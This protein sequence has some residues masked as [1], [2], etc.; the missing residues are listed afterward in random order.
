MESLVS[1][2]GSLSLQPNPRARYATA[3]EKAVF[4]DTLTA[5]IIGPYSVTTKATLTNG[6]CL[7]S[8]VYRAAEAQGFPC[9]IASVLGGYTGPMPGNIRTKEME[10][11]QKARFL[12]S[13]EIT[14]EVNELY[15]AMVDNFEN[16]KIIYDEMIG[17]NT[18]FVRETLALIKRYIGSASSH[19]ERIENKASFIRDYK[20]NIINLVG[21]NIPGGRIYSGELENNAI[22]RIIQLMCG[23]NIITISSELNTQEIQVQPNT[24][25]IENQGGGHY[26]YFAI[27][28]KLPDRNPTYDEV[29]ARATLVLSKNIINAIVRESNGNLDRTIDKIIEVYGGKPMGLNRVVNTNFSAE[30]LRLRNGRV[31]G[32]GR[33]TR[34]RRKTKRRHR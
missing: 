15:Y 22:T 31:P 1:G 19:A 10:F 28:A 32:G 24:I 13:E 25:Y 21:D 26:E 27:G 11:V 33:R 5:R 12:V 16:N 8:S 9:V 29:V 34:R 6:D 23:I 3:A 2:I 30:Y 20:N 17:Q 18:T 7:Y 4:R 14:E